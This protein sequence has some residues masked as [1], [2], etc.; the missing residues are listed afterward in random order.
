MTKT[1][2]GMAAIVLIGGLGV[3]A[4]STP[5][6]EEPTST[7]VPTDE[8]TLTPAAGRR[9]DFQSDVWKVGACAPGA[10]RIRCVRHYS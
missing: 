10:S 7:A 9:G 5:P 1:L 3:V 2:M 8:P 4:C 6:A